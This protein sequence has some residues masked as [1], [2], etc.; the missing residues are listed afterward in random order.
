MPTF[1]VGLRV[2]RAALPALL[3]VACTSTDRTA[4]DREAAAVRT[5]EP[6]AYEVVIQDDLDEE[7]HAFL[8]A[9]S[10]AQAGRDSPPTSMLAL[11]RRANEDADR[12]TRALHSEGYYDAS[13]DAAVTPPTAQTQETPAAPAILDFTVEKGER[14]RF[15]D[16]RIEP[17]DPPAGYAPPAPENLGLEP[18][19]PARAEVVLEALATLERRALEAGHAYATLGEDTI[20]I[21][22][23]RRTMDV[24]LRIEPG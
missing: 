13:V 6:I 16:L 18:G 19:A 9:V 14:Y 22:R 12:L 15:A 20:V 7:L 24:T 10:E 8:L 11:R 4:L 1:R 17:I 23:E 3:V 2:L 21:D 5:G